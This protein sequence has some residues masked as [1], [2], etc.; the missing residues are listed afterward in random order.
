MDPFQVHLCPCLTFEMSHSCWVWP[1]RFPSFLGERAL[2]LVM[3]SSQVTH[4]EGTSPAP[5]TLPAEL[6]LFN[7]A[8]CFC[9]VLQFLIRPQCCLA[10]SFFCLQLVTSCQY[11]PLS[12]PCDVY[13][14]PLLGKI[15]H[16]HHRQ[17]LNHYSLLVISECV[18]YHGT[19]CTSV[20]CTAPNLNHWQWRKNNIL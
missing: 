5:L 2:R 19:I 9:K 7:R 13:H 18:A 20:L 10:W 11:Y 8:P 4:R 16:T 15:N 1:P 12:F 3:H 17:I 6:C 14:L